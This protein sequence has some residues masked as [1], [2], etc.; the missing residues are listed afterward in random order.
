MYKNTHKQQHK[1]TLQMA[2]V[3]V[4]VIPWVVRLYVELIHKL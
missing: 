1:P 4:I 3:Y 2:I